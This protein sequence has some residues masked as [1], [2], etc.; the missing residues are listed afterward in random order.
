MHAVFIVAVVFAGIVIALAVVGATIL[1]AIKLRHGRVTGADQKNQAEEARI[2]QELYQGLSR[3]EERVEA[4]ETIL[5]D[6]KGKGT[7]K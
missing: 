4:L 2:I 3:M 1:M 5:L 6:G 7:S